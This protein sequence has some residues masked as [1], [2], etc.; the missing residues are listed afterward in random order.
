MLH[1]EALSPQ[2]S[3][4][5][6]NIHKKWQPKPDIAAQAQISSY[7]DIQTRLTFACNVLFFVLATRESGA[8]FLM[9]QMHQR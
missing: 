1:S 2:F 5:S 6:C 3:G 8:V 4:A 7:R 9:Q